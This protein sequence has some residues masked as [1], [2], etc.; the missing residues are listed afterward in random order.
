[1]VHASFK[2]AFTSAEVIFEARGQHGDQRIYSL[3]STSSLNLLSFCPF[4][5]L[6][7]HSHDSSSDATDWPICGMQS[8]DVIFSDS[9]CVEPQL[10]RYYQYHVL[11]PN[12]KP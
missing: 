2:D 1:M 8:V 7:N 12:G 3:F 11:P 10:S 6:R 9:A 4:P 5:F